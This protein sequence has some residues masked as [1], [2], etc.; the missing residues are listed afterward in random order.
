MIIV[1]QSPLTRKINAMDLDI[2]PRQLF[3]WKSGTLAQDAF[4]NLS[5]DEREFVIS[6]LTADDW[7]AL[8]GDGSE[9]EDEE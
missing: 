9:S 1:R 4:P 6:G 7:N 5:P 8:Y 3:A 2:T